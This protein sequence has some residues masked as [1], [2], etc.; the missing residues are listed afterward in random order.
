MESKEHL[1][2]KQARAAE[3]REKSLQERG[4]NLRMLR[5]KVGGCK[6]ASRMEDGFR[7]VASRMENGFSVVVLRVVA[8]EHPPARSY[9]HTPLGGGDPGVEERV[10]TAGSR[11]HGEA[12]AEG[13]G[14]EADPAEDEGEEGP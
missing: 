6:V 13:R 1:D 5:K 12:T 11:E 2:E 7:V 4:E 3:L 14:E 8:A 10:A 9:H